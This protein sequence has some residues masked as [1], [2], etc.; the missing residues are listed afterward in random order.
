MPIFLA[1]HPADSTKGLSTQALNKLFEIFPSILP[2][3]PDCPSPSVAFPLIS[4][5][6]ILEGRL[7][8]AYGFEPGFKD[9]SPGW[10]ERVFSQ[11]QWSGLIRC[12]EDP[13][14]WIK[15]YR[16]H[17]ESEECREDR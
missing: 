14:Q 1:K 13:W 15:E 3:E 7:G 11:I 10:G 9:V 4:L 5:S 6:Q 8:L 12:L 16:P 17:D 2:V